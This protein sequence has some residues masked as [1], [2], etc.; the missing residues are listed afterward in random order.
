[1]ICMTCPVRVKCKEYKNATKSTD[2]IWAGEYSQ[3][4]KSDN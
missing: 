3:R 1:M 4:K 2:G